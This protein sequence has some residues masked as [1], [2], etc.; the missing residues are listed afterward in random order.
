MLTHSKSNSSKDYITTA[1]TS[2]FLSLPALSSSS[3]PPSLPPSS[4]LPSPPAK[5][6]PQTKKL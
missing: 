5:F 6:G 3:L 1:F 4:H 2:T